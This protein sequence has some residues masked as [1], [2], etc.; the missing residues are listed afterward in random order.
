M[1]SLNFTRYKKLENVVTFQNK[2]DEVYKI[3]K[4]T[5]RHINYSIASF[6]KSAEFKAHNF[7]NHL[8]N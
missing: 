2:N 7:L 4:F 6:P 3:I 8:Y 5:P 1:T